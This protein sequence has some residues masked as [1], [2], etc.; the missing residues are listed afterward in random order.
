MKNLSSIIKRLLFLVFVNFV[1]VNSLY[2]QITRVVYKNNLYGGDI[3]ATKLSDEKTKGLSQKQVGLLEEMKRNEANTEFELFFNK[4][5]SLYQKVE[6]LDIVDKSNFNKLLDNNKYYKN[7][8]TNVKLYQIEKPELF[9][10]I[11]PFEQYKWEITTETKIING[12]KCYK[13]TT[14][15]EDMYNP[16]KDRRLVFNPVVWFTPEIP[17]SFGPKGLDGLPGLVLEASINGKKYLYASK[18]EFDFKK[19]KEIER[20]KGGKDITKD[21][22]EKIIIE[23]FRKNQ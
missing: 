13:A 8:E 1:F 9:N 20:P 4:K 16:F 5:E 6:K 10:V 3:N 21:D 2:C 18:I 23:N 7:I 17:A 22:L 15:Y 11:V 19:S 14:T 12:Y